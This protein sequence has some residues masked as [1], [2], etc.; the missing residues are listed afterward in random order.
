MER[1]RNDLRLAVRSLRRTPTFAIAVLVILGLG[2]GMAVAMFTTVTE[3]LVRRLPVQD[4]DRIAVLW[5]YNVPTIEMS[6]LGS[7]MPAIRHAVRTMR[8]VAGVVHWG[9]V[10]T[11]LLDGDHT[12]VLGLAYVT[13]NY[14]DVLGARP[15]LGRL[16]RPED[17][18]PGAPPVV[19]LSHSLWQSQF[20]GSPSVIGRHLID[21]WTRQS[22]AIVGVAP[23]GLDYPVGADCWKAMGTEVAGTVVLA[24]GRLAPGAT[25]D[26]ARAEFFSI[27]SRL[28]PGWKL[29][30]ATAE[31]LTTAVVGNFRPIL[32]A[33]TSA[34]G[35]LLLIACV[36]IG[37]LFLVRAAARTRELAVR[38]A[39]G[40]SYWDT[41]R[42]LIVESGLLAVAGGALG[43]TCAAVMLRGFVAFA[44]PKMPHLDD[45]RLHSSL[46]GAAI[47]VTSIAVLLFGVVP[48]LV[49]AQA[50]AESS[51]RWDAR[52][53]R[54][55]RQRRTVRQWLVASQVALALVMLSGAGL[56]ARSLLGLERLR[57]GYQ[58]AHLSILSLALDVSK[59][60]SSAA[61]DPV[62]EQ[63]EARIRAIPGV[64]AVT[65]ILM[66]PFLGTNVWH[67][68][69]EAEGES[70]VPSGTY[71]DFPIEIA[72]PQYFRAFEIPIIRGRSFAESDGENAPPV[73][74]VSQSVAQRFWPGQD[75]IG[76]RIRLP[77]ASLGPGTVVRA[78][79]EPYLVWRTVVGVVPDTRF[80][81]LRE[82][83]PMVYYPWQQY[84]SWQGIIA[85]RST[86]D[87]RG[88]AAAVQNTVKAI[89]PTIAV[90]GVRSMDELLGVPLAEPRLTALLLTSFGAVALLLAAVGLFGA[91]SSA[92]RE[93]T[94]EIGIRVALGATPAMIRGSVVRR[95][96]VVISTG[97]AVGLAVALATTRVLGSLLY[98]VSPAD[99]ITLAFV[100]VVLLVVAG[101]AAYLP[102]RRATRIDPIVA[103]R[104]D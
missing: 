82:S 50:T 69:F 2:I 88:V 27:V 66:P 94:R 77:R 26:A 35:L 7:D 9:A 59:Y 24:V 19:V 8:D 58:T 25:L 44:P 16:L 45:V 101:V 78:S 90:Y 89:D 48:A 64:S 74:V 3:V 98:Q 103:L 86:G 42:P 11:P 91:M 84:Q 76:K 37:T 92:V 71:P 61:I 6:A 46:L 85:V 18:A 72:G 15:A 47:G 75:P 13:A 40:A 54:E 17:D 39:L 62:I 83:S 55:T 56:L 23:P 102:A 29:T 30:G 1:L 28:Q 53:G 14:F 21:P 10:R 63:V 79:D 67:P 34:V 104:A 81:T 20:G 49:A 22:Y 93:Q 65:P 41:V 32:V 97:M 57:L 52:S 5:T 73:V 43:V 36:N 38:R 12:L 99:P 87:A 51:L 95:A 31:T 100:C 96:F 80:R 4:Q 70:A 68:P 60:D 33:I